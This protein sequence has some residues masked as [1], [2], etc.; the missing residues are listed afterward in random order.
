LR[1]VRFRATNDGKTTNATDLAPTFTFRRDYVVPDGKADTYDP[2]VFVFAVLNMFRDIE[3]LYRPRTAIQ[4]IV[5]LGYPA[6]AIGCLSSQSPVYR[7]AAT[8][9]LRH[10]VQVRTLQRS[11]KTR[12]RRR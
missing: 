8:A 5:G 10:V 7:L 9:I 2:R 4:A 12:E 3:E 6:V 1:L 11:S